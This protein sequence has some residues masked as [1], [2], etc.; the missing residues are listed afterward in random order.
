MGLLTI[1]LITWISREQTHFLKPWGKS[2]H[3]SR[4]GSRLNCNIKC[5]LKKR[6]LQILTG[7]S[8][9]SLP[10]KTVDEKRLIGE[11]AAKMAGLEK[12]DNQLEVK[13]MPTGRN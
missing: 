12:V 8:V 10:V 5:T 7:A 11:I 2:P 4:A 6:K 3:V 1:S 9:V 13:L